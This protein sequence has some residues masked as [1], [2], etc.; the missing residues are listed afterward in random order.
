MGAFRTLDSGKTIEPWGKNGDHDASSIQVIRTGVQHSRPAN[1]VSHAN[2]MQDSTKSCSIATPEPLH[3]ALPQCHR[4][5]VHVHIVL[6][7]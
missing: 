7:E 1:L 2:E 5:W 3:C 6:E 4:R